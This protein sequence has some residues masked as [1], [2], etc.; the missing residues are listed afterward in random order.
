MTDTGKV[1]ILIYEKKEVLFFHDFFREHFP[2]F[3]VMFPPPGEDSLA[4]C[5]EE[6]PDLIILDVF[7]TGIYGFTLCRQIKKH[8]GLKSTPVLAVTRQRTGSELG[9]EAVE[10]GADAIIAHPTRQKDLLIWI[11]LLLRLKRLEDAASPETDS[12]NR[13]LRECISQMEAALSE[14]KR[15]EESVQ[16]ER[17]FA[18]QVMDAM[19]Q[20][21]TI[22][23]S[24]GLFQYVNKAFA[25][26]LGYSPEE[27]LGSAPRDFTH[28]DDRVILAEARNL[29]RSGETNT[30]EIRMITRERQVVPV[31]IT[32]VPY[33]R[34]GSVAGAIAVVTNI[35]ELK[36][37][38]K[39][40]TRLSQ[41]YERVF[42]GSGEALFLVEVTN[43][44][45]FRFTRTNPTHQRLTGIPLRE[46]VGKTPVELLGEELGTRIQQNYLRCVDSREP[47]T[48][49]EV[50]LLP[51]GKRWW[52][53][54][55][56]PVIDKG[57]VVF[58]VG[59][60]T[61]IT[62]YK[63]LEAKFRETKNPSGKEGNKGG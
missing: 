23:N 56:S 45:K 24:D 57:E 36:Q 47:I 1:L 11:R 14:R 13:Q 53:T 55:L 51:G 29:R 63:L 43:G 4:V 35:S 21:L 34:G 46:I 33:F 37:K 59:S 27:M 17:E 9:R 52:E 5:I 39:E 49:E 12:L 58:I 8:A 20:G 15:A 18:R 62:R 2:G 32:G 38:E 31:I 44:S 6:Q 26:M 22:T 25:N 7:S 48:Y 54:S 42:N 40:L 19:G 50:I 61:E 60:G 10:A 28:S 41:D 3:R 30:Y 16:V